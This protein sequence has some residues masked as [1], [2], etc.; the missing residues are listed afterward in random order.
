MARADRSIKE[1]QPLQNI[2]AS[3][4]ES[5][6]LRIGG[7]V[8]EQYLMDKGTRSIWEKDQERARELGAMLSQEKTEPWPHAANALLP[9]LSVACL[10]F[11]ARALKAFI[12]DRTVAYGKVLGPVSDEVQQIADLVGRRLSNQC[13]DE[14][15]A[16]E[17]HTDELLLALPVNGCGFRKTVYDPLRGV[18]EQPFVAAEDVVMDY[19]AHF[20]ET[21][22]ISHLMGF[23]PHQIEARE[24]SG[25]WLGGMN[26]APDQS[27][28][29]SNVAFN[30]QENRPPD[31]DALISFIEQH[32]WLDMDGDGYREPYVAT[33]HQASRELVRLT[34]RW[35]DAQARYDS[36]G[37]VL[38]IEPL[39]YFTRYQFLPALDGGVYGMGFGKLLGTSNDIVNSILNQMVD[40][41][42]LQ[43]VGGGFLRGGVRVGRESA[44]PSRIRMGEYTPVDGVGDD[45]R[46]A[47]MPHAHPGPSPVLFNLLGVM[48]DQ[49]N[50]LSMSTDALTG[51]SQPAGT[52]AATTLTL[53]EQGLQVYTAAFRRIFRAFKQDLE[54]VV[55]CNV[56]YK[57]DPFWISVVSMDEDEDGRMDVVPVADP[58]EATDM[59]RIA[60]ARAALEVVGQGGADRELFRRYL[61][62]IGD[63]Q[64]DAIFPPDDDQAA[65][66]VQQAAVEADLALQD[67]KLKIDEGKLQL[68]QSRLTL[69]MEKLQADIELT[70][71][72]ALKAVADAEAAEVG[73]QLAEYQEMVKQLTA[74]LNTVTTRMEEMNG[75]QAPYPNGG[76]GGLA[77]VSRDPSLSPAPET[78]GPAVAG[79]PITG[80]DLEPELGRGDVG[81]YGPQRG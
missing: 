73:D 71:A 55:R 5:E 24:R 45:V 66:E 14:I 47:I 15:P 33:V 32:R 6:R 36:R 34:A 60:R 54:H 63:E 21:P 20:H 26:F 65:V 3:L 22:R 51:G 67:R 50:K 76:M 43:N 29:S 7:E 59:Q 48:M 62:A 30:Q 17:E 69:E 19:K 27:T 46:K 75:N 25:V 42:T 16:W 57:Q 77:P 70:K 10:Q 74:D 11:Q 61:R 44:G 2:A 53:V 1:L 68:E 39:Q 56:L 12:K 28:R 23:Y 80:L 37:K 8:V 40:A 81:P 49:A 79:E 64:A 35:D 31:P 38:W 18:V 78:G 4:D 13:F 52:P 58:N 72:Q 9:L 41:A